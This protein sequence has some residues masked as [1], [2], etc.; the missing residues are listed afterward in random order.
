MSFKKCQY[1]SNIM[2][3]FKQ[4]W[5]F[6]GGWA[7]DLFLGK[8]T[9]IHEDIEI[10]IFRENQFDLKR[11]LNQWEFKKVLNGNITPWNNEYLELPI[12][13]VHAINN[14]NNYALEILLNESHNE[15]WIFRRDSRICYSLKSALLF[16]TT[17]LPYL[18]PEIVLLY[19][20][21]NIRRKDHKDFLSVKDHL[22]I[23]QK[24][25]LKESL[26]IQNPNHKWLDFI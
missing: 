1:V 11:F 21:K 15:N 22:N 19:K 23:D 8:E 20:S 26:E 10:G 9:R 16:T 13:E 6:A 4:P 12:H 17:G 25:W 24:N 2:S 7:I 5:F 14:L 3:D 18:A